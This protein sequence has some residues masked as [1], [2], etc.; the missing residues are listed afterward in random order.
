MRTVIAS[1]VLAGRRIQPAAFAMTLAALAVGLTW[2]GADRVAGPYELVIGVAGIAAAGVLTAGWLINRTAIMR[3]GLLLSVAVWCLVAWVAWTGAHSITSALL[4]LAW[5]V[6]AG[7][8]Y[9]LEEVE[10]QAL[11][12]SP[13]GRE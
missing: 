2:I 9:W 1:V 4:A 7:G 10:A 12:P 6:L 5:A 11:K 3:A 13:A 8:S